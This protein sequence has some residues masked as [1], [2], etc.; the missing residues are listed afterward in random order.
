MHAGGIDA[1]GDWDLKYERT[2][3]FNQILLTS[4]ISKRAQRPQS[5]MSNLPTPASDELE[6]TCLRGVEHAFPTKKLL[7]NTGFLRPITLPITYRVTKL[8]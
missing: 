2:D 3:G 8:S 4:C 1:I 5:G 7:P 6:W